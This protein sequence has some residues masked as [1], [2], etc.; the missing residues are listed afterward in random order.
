MSIQSGA[1]QMIDCLELLVLRVA[2]DLGASSGQTDHASNSFS[3]LGASLYS[4]A[5]KQYCRFISV[6]DV[7][8]RV[9]LGNLGNSFEHY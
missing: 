4:A 1:I 8:G 5:V 6:G 9:K 2:L 7:S 3:S